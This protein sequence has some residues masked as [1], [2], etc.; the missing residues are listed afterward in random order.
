MLNSDLIQGAAGAAEYTGLP[1]RM[2][3][4]MVENQQ[5]PVIRRGRRL[6]FRRS[7]L[8]AAFRSQGDA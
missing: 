7:E 6:F 8:E 1:R 4:N 3:Y 5:L 2:I